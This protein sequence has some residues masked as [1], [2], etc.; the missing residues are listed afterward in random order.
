MRHPAPSDRNCYDRYYFNLH[1][2]SGEYFAIFGLGQYPNEHGFF[3]D[4]CG[5]PRGSAPGGLGY[6]W[7]SNAAKQHARFMYG[8]SGPRASQ[9]ADAAVCGRF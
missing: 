3:G 4:P 1:P 9:V 7:A 5:R 8:P 2:S 6:G